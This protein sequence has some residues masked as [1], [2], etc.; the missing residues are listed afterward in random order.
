MLTP[1]RPGMSKVYTAEEVAKH[2]KPDDCW[3][4]INE[5]VLNV[6]D[7]LP[8]HPGGKN[9]ILLCTQLSAARVLRSVL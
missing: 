9:A 3:V 2:N 6:T 4:I 1:C 8:D 5:Q 7:F